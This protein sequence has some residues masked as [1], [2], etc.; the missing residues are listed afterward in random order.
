MDGTPN[1]HQ[2][3][4][5][6]QGADASGTKTQGGPDQERDERIEQCRRIGSAGS[7]KYEVAEG[8]QRQNENGGFEVIRASGAQRWPAMVK[9]ADDGGG[10]GEKGQGFGEKI[11]PREEPGVAAGT[12]DADKG[13]D[14]GG[15]ENGEEGVLCEG[16]KA[17][18]TGPAVEKITGAPSSDQNFDSVRQNEPSDGGDGHACLPVVK[19]KTGQARREKEGPYSAW[20]E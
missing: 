18:Q 19:N 3:D 5:G 20:D 10:Y 11:K 16:A 15:Q 1:G 4:D 13:D 9:Q 8:A 12:L 6:A 14:D 17:V 7:D 2:G